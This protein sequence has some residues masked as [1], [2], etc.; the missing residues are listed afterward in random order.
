METPQRVVDNMFI[1]LEQK[2]MR[3]YALSTNEDAKQE[4]LSLL[5]AISKYKLKLH[6]AISED[7]KIT[8]ILLTEDTEITAEIMAAIGETAE[9]IKIKAND[10]NIEKLES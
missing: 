4:M 6:Q 10:N 9:I 8:K 2:A 7:K 1:Y 5:Q 3:A